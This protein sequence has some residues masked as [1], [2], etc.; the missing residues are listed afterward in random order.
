[1][2]HK[3]QRSVDAE[4]PPGKRLRDNVVDLYASGGIPGGRAQSILEDAGAFAAEMGRH[5]MQDLRAHKGPGSSKNVD[6]DLRV[7]LLK[8]SRCEVRVQQGSPK[9]PHKS[10]FPLFWYCPESLAKQ[11]WFDLQAP[12]ETLLP[13]SV[14]VASC[15]HPSSSLL[16]CERQA[17]G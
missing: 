12:V 17:A 6:R 14:K 2:W 16:V 11:A 4:A 7:K 8:R 10:G 5:E 15:L 9:A 3:R 1:M 13:P